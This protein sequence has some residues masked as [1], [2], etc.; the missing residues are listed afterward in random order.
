MPDF[1][2]MFRLN[3]RSVDPAQQYEDGFHL[4]EAA[5]RLGLDSVWITS[6]HFG[7]DKGTIASP[8]LYLA[9]AAQRTRR[10]RLGA[11]VVVLSL[12]D[13]IRVAEDAALTDIISQGRLRL[14]LGSGL[15]DWSFAAFGVDW[16]E[17]HR[18]FDSKLRGLK[19]MLA[20]A[21]LP[22]GKRLHPPG[23][24][25]LNKIWRVGTELD[26]VRRI[27]KE[28]DNLLLGSSKQLSLAQNRERHAVAIR[29]FRR[30]AGPAR[31]IGAPLSLFALPDGREARRQFHDALPDV[32]KTSAS[33][34]MTRL[35]PARRST[36]EA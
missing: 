3:D 19:Q 26:D 7:S 24:S 28:G 21:E 23:R 17:R 12:E 33:R 4:I 2:I 18:I 34:R 14:G 9:A 10:I 11:A 30:L 16:A 20:G 22:G 35:R 29:E 15:E 25:L 32:L 13:P 36:S 6:H 1:G 27:A 5:E 31:R 8:L